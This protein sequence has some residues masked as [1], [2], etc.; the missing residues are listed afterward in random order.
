M[1]AIPIRNSANLWPHYFK[2]SWL[3]KYCKTPDIHLVH[4]RLKLR[5]ANAIFPKNNTFYLTI[6][7]HP[8]PQWASIFTYF[9]K[10]SLTNKTTSL[11]DSMNNYMDFYENYKKKILGAWGRNPNFYDLGYDEST[12]TD[13][14][15]IS[16][17][18]QTIDDSFDFVMITELWEES[19]LLLKEKMCMSIDE[20][21]MFEVNSRIV[22]SPELPESLKDRILE[23]NNADHQLYDYFYQKLKK[24]ALQL[25]RSDFDNYRKR[26]KF[27]EDVCIGGRTK[28]VSYRTKK[29][30]GYK[31]KSNIDDKYRIQCEQMVMSEIEIFEMYK[32]QIKNLT[33]HL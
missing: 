29:Y 10:K 6:L 26:K 21:I 9:N 30:L 7:R 15:S 17:L 4:C 24:E 25:D 32:H 27:W 12:L 19:V 33:K 14:Q 16:T 8:V 28:K 5:L 18:I 1:L 23:F 2:D 13:N 22:K 20:I 11:F 3:E 31:L